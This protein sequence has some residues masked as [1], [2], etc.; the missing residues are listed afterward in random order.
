ML[1]TS[2]L[3]LGAI[4]VQRLPLAF[5]PQ[6]D[7]PFIGVEVPYI[8][9]NPAQVERDITKPLEETLATLSGVQRLRSRSSADGAF[10]QLDFDWGYDLD[11]IRMQVSE[12]VDQIKPELPE[13]IG[14]VLI[15]SFNTTDIPVVQGRISAEGVDLSANYELLEARVLNR[16]R[17]VPGVARV[18]LDGVEPR[19]IFIELVIDKI[20][21][22]GVDVGELTGKLRNATSNLVL[23]E[24]YSDG[25]RYTARAIGEYGSVGELESLVLDARGLRLSDVAEVHYEEPPIRYGRH[26]NKKDAIAL[27]VHKESTANTVD[28]VH[29]VLSVIENEISQDPLLQGINLFMWDNQADQI[30]GAIDGLTRAGVLGALLAVVVLYF[31]LRRL[32]TTLIV[33][34]SIP[35]SI[36]AACG[37]MYFLGM[38]LNVLSMMGLMLGVGM[39]VDN[40][41]VVLEAIDRHKRKEA[42]PAKAALGGAKSVGLAV[43]AS[44]VTSLI[45]FLPLIV[46]SRSQLTTWLGEVGITIALALVCSLLSSLTLIPLMASRFLSA[47]KSEPVALITRLEDVYVKLLG[48]TLK[49]PYKTFAVIVLGAV[50]GFLP[51]FTGMVKA[52]QFGAQV[53]ERLYLEYEFSDFVYKSQAEAIVDQVED[54][55]Y[56]R[57]EELTIGSIYSYYASNE[58]GTTLTLSRKDLDE[59]EIKE[60][61]SKIRDGLPEIPGVKV[62]FYEDADEGGASTYFS[63]NFFGQDSTV[64]MKLADEAERRLETVDGVKDVSSSIGRASQEIQVKID[65]AKAARLGLTAREVAD[66]FSFVL[67]SFRL[68]RFSDG[69]REVET[70]LALRLEDRENLADLE[71]IQFREIEGRPVLLGDVATFEVVDK[72]EV[73]EREN[74]K[75]RVGVRATYEG[76]DWGEARQQIT[77]LM[78]AFDLPG[79]YSWS[80]NQRILEDDAQDNEMGWNFLLALAMVYIVMAALFESLAQPFAILFSI[81][82]ALPG[83]AWILGLTGTPFN[84]MAQIGLLILMGIVVNNGIVLLDH[85]NQLRNEGLSTHD[86]ILEAGR[87]RMRAIL[88]TAATT[89]IGLVP[90][91]LGG[92]ETG[93]L[94][95]YPLALTVMGGLMSSSILTLTVLPWVNLRIE[96][97]AR[98]LRTV[99]T[100]SAPSGRPVA[101]S[102]E[103]AEAA[104]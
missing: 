45:V 64:L 30:T 71:E 84:L 34:L 4:A 9:T 38:T 36:L 83:T 11:V 21:E 31:F 74:R 24:V 78:D 40:A 43:F 28:V 5:L 89:I 17:R 10:V 22:H 82:F 70:W 3:L 1:L 85:M 18:E 53:N 12:K 73:I 15:Y 54:Y 101:A 57:R 100:R 97:V 26:L 14:E 25:R 94:F 46:G 2:I 92:T 69:E 99:W 95:Y 65:R 8:N 67:G 62:F 91:A 98:W 23:G 58:A 59:K 47:R 60:L 87:D 41:I 55:L 29:A 39:L 44:T 19:E 81:P 80:Y 32:G 13:G 35:F 75:V 50:V 90:L 66:T 37:V 61:R 77:G 63:V 52:S 79:G 102:G 103:A 56:P 76:E 7:I 42:D 27:I 104:G 48:W 16:I 49:H 88:M 86:A 68:P 93:G 51:F 20:K 33:S 72:P 96:W 6:I